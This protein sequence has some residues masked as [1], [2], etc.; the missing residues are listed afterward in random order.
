MTATTT[1][2]RA[3]GPPPAAPRPRPRPARG[4]LL[5]HG[6]ALTGRSLR[7]LKHSPEQ[8]VD[9]TLQ[10]IIFVVLFVYLFGGAI[11]G[12]RHAYLQYVLP[13]ILVQTVA[14]ASLGT[15]I[16]LN[17]DIT[18]GIFDRFRSLPI[19]RSAPLVGTVVGDLVRYVVSIA[20]LFAFGT[21]L[22]FRVGTDPLSALAACAV[23]LLFAFA[24]C[25][26]AAW[27]GLLVRSVRA[28]QGVGFL[29]MFP[30]TFGSNLFVESDT[31]PGW[32]RAW[33]EVNPVTQVVD[34][35][36]GLLLGGAVAGP[37]AA[38]LAW[39]AAILAV[40]VPLSLVAYRR[41]T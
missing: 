1:T 33:V 11:T 5:R 18:T 32:L 14:F 38:T 36:R 19:A 10:P 28:V 21:V 26:I 17:T 9:L 4:R 40:F 16:G 39:T 20:V 12:D 30:L 31:L 22:G 23:V 6:L 27:I 24:L 2:S 29:L 8:L 15:G 41:R 7:K 34:V 35:A 37:L 13:G 3:A 25:W